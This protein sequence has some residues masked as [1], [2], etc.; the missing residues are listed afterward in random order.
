MDQAIANI[1]FLLFW[2]G[3]EPELNFASCSFKPQLPRLNVKI[4]ACGESLTQE[5]SPIPK[6]LKQLFYNLTLLLRLR[7]VNMTKCFLVIKRSAL[8]V[9]CGVFGSVTPVTAARRGSD[10]QPFL[11]INALTML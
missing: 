8:R 2:A 4:N 3:S 6:S 5:H 10:Q 1:L 7:D 9:R 11:C